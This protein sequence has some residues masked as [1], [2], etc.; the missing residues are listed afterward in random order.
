MRFEGTRSERFQI[1]HG[2]GIDRD[3]NAAPAK[4][5][6]HSKAVRVAEGFRTAEVGYCKIDI[7]LARPARLIPPA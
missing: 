5:F 3:G 2:L 6:A 7:S 1:R 4:A